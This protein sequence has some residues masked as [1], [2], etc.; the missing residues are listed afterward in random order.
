MHL[1]FFF[2]LGKKI[3]F[4]FPIQSETFDYIY[5]GEDL[6]AQASK[7]CIKMSHMIIADS[8]ILHLWLPNFRDIF[9]THCL[10]VCCSKN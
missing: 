1:L 10:H 3:N 8:L 9:S 7:F 5:D 2:S 4:L 6:I